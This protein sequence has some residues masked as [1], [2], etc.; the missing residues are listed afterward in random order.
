MK[1]VFFIFIISAILQWYMKSK[2]MRKLYSHYD[3]LLKDGDVLV[4][5]SKGVFLGAV[6]M[7]QLNEKGV[8]TDCLILKGATFF[9]DWKKYESLINKDLTN[10]NAK[11]FEQYEKPIR[12]ALK[13]AIKNYK[14][15]VYIRRYRSI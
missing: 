15:K 5:K 8:I 3:N 2:Q 7:L 14:K 9:S 4:E 6:V 12:N 10:F 13:K 1:L 11:D